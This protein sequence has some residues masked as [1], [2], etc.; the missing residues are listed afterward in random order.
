[1]HIH[2][3]VIERNST[4][5]QIRRIKN[6]C[7]ISLNGG[8]NFPELFNII[9]IDCS[10][11]CLY[12]RWKIYKLARRKPSMC[13]IYSFRLKVINT[14]Q[15]FFF[16][17]KNWISWLQKMAN[18]LGKRGFRKVNASEKK[19]ERSNNKWLSF[20]SPALDFPKWKNREKCGSVKLPTGCRK[21][22][23]VSGTFGEACRR[24]V[25]MRRQL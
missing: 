6:Y 15:K 11:K 4:W 25:S 12:R 7:S 14:L 9:W 22:E 5:W 21:I 16:L 23:R 17:A 1:M 10:C 18:Q 8:G 13:V 3:H 20:E 19:S 2:T 24:S